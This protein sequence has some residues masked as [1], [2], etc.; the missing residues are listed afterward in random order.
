MATGQAAA[1][2]YVTLGNFSV[3]LNVTDAQGLW[4]VTQKQIQIG[5]PHCPS[6]AFTINP[7]F[8]YVD[9]ELILNASA[10][11]PGWNGTHENPVIFLTWDFGDGNVTSSHDST[12]IHSYT[13]AG[14][15]N[16]TLTVSDSE[17]M[18]ASCSQ[19]ILV[20]MPTS[21][22]IS[23]NA[24]SSVIGYVV[25]ING[26]LNDIY[27]NPIGNEPV[28]LYYT[29]PG[30]T[31]VFPMTASTTDDNGQYSAQWIPTA[32][33]TYCLIAEWT[34]NMTYSGARNNVT[35]SCLYAMTQYIFSV[36]SNSSIS[37]LAFNTTSLELA[38]TASG[39][40][41]TS[42]YV[43]ITWRKAS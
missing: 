43:K 19:T 40:S 28:V 26:T 38:F 10:T 30:I 41:G 17:N 29:F 16:V 2:A 6:A 3:T 27:G 8:T 31:S 14:D 9:Q 39:P 23:T 35:M 4:N 22:S 37:A 20:V 15:F 21:M 33:G 1:H 18:S 12:I 25:S 34:G 7:K 36:E 24:T 32:T 42:G 11:L 5:Q 13:H